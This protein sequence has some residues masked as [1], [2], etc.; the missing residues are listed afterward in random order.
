MLMY[1][2]IKYS[3]NYSDTS[4]NL[5]QFKRDEQS[6]NIGYPDNLATNNSSPFKYKSGFLEQ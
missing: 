6:M 2:L 4:G 1:N 3:H 5:W